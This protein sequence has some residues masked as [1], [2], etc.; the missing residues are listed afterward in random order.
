MVII[1]GWR[2]TRCEPRARPQPGLSLT[3]QVFFGMLLL[4]SFTACDRAPAPVPAQENATR[5][6]AGETG[7]V[8]L[9]LDEVTRSGVTVEPVGRM[10]F[11]TYRT[12]PGVVRPNEHALANITTLVRGRVAE[13]HADLGQMVKPHQLLAVL[14][15]SDLGLAQS[16]HLKARARRHVAEQ[17]YQR[18]QF[19]Y[20]EKV[21]GQAEAQ[22]REGEMIS[23]RAEAQEAREGLRLLG[24]GDKE[25]ET[26]ERTQTIRSQVPIVAPF[27]GRVI[28]RDLTKGEV[29]ET[30]HKLFAVA[31]L[32]TVWVVGN[33]SEKDISYLHRATVSPNQP[34]EVFVAAYPDEVFRG[35]VTYVGDVLDTATRTMQVRLALP[36]PDSRLKPEMFATI[37]V[38]SES[39]SDVLVV[40][41]AAIQHDRGR[42]FVFVQKE[43][44]VFEARTI[45]VG[46]KNG[47][48]AEVLEGV[49]EKELVVK[50]GAFTLKSEL[51]KPKD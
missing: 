20:E 49:Q 32:S 48:S 35:T 25:I 44:G 12:F 31:D 50:E 8:R 1:S 23:V 18:A 41:E 6:S 9:P 15:S 10:V 11:R 37:R 21:I 24:M 30:T 5:H 45:Q 46:E 47:A 4:A 28:A 22:R 38:L 14:H 36:N 42:S 17:A 26:L 34:V 39:A 19:L 29:V 40:P 27:A 2:I 3:V 51:L 43:P 33:V 7:L 16:A 13:V